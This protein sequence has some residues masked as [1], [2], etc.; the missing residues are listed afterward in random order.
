[1]SDTSPFR[2]ELEAAINARHSRLSPFT[3]EWVKGALIA[4]TAAGQPAVPESH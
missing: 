1:M 3:D 4:D 2:R